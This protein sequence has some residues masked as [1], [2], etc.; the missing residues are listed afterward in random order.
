[1]KTSIDYKILVLIPTYKGSRFIERAIKSVKTTLAGYPYKIIVGMDGFDRKTKAIVQQHPEIVWM[2]FPVSGHVGRAKNRM[3]AAARSYIT[4][5]TWI[6][7]CDDDDWMAQGMT[8]LVEATVRNLFPFSVGAFAVTLPKFKHNI[9]RPVDFAH[10]SRCG[11]GPQATLMHSSLIP[12]DGKLFPETGTCEDMVLWRQWYAKGIYPAIVNTSPVCVYTSDRKMSASRITADYDVFM[13]TRE[14]VNYNTYAL[15]T[16]PKSFSTIVDERS[17]YEYKL[18]H[19]S[20]R[21][22]HP[23]TPIFV[24]T[25]AELQSECKL[26]N[27]IEP[28]VGLKRNENYLKI[29]RTKTKICATALRLMQNTC[30]VDA[31]MI[32]LEPMGFVSDTRPAVVAHFPDENWRQSV[33]GV[34]QAGLLFFT[35]EEQVAWLDKEYSR[36]KVV[37]DKFYTEQKTVE[38]FAAVFNADQLPFGH[39]CGD[40]H[41]SCSFQVGYGLYLYARPA[42]SVHAHVLTTDKARSFFWQKDFI[43]RFLSA[44]S[45]STYPPHKAIYKAYLKFSNER[46]QFLEKPQARNGKWTAAKFDSHPAVQRVNSVGGR[47][48]H[49]RNVSDQ[50]R[51]SFLD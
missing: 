9:C 37:D 32:L 6:A 31:D 44:L 33:W 24:A 25:T 17:F 19:A 40:W 35:H 5:T 48:Q 20:I 47:K 42:F 2:E 18:L 50:Q 30:Y 22:F 34:Y 27:L 21:Q 13:R 3:L 38:A 46:Q 26:D 7:W 15:P 39:D 49:R 23:Q 45:Q 11:F 43:A 4:P 12:A 8:E 16:P 41:G 14:L 1:M 51:E 28:F 36:G 29:F 10:W